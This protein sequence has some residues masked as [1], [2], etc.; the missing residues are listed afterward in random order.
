[1][2]ILLIAATEA[3]IAL[4]IKHIAS[5]GTA[6]TPRL[7]N[8]SGHMV[9]ICITGVGMV[10]TTYQLT[11][12]LADDHYD[13]AIQAGI[14]GSFDRNYPLGEVVRVHTDRFADIGAEDGDNYLSAFEMGLIDPKEAPFKTQLLENPL[15]DQAYLPELPPVSA[16][17]VNTVS[18]NETTVQQRA[19]RYN[20]TLESM[21]GAAFHYV[22]LLDKQPF[23]QIR[24]ISNYVERRNRDNWQIGPAI[25][26]LNGFLI[27]YLDKLMGIMP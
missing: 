5:I 4:S 15:S 3:E 2:K 14:A 27:S 10:A 12:L 18:G 6:E 1:M 24:A 8:C 21:E 19:E 7:F 25:G 9:R 20:S 23:I 11:K 22:C 16:I 26:N 17:T 13:L